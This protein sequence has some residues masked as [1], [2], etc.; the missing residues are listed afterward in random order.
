MPMAYDAVNALS[1][2]ETRQGSLN[3]DE[4]GE[5]KKGPTLCNQRQAPQGCRSHEPGRLALGRA[6]CCPCRTRPELSS[7]QDQNDRTTVMTAM[8]TGIQ[9]TIACLIDRRCSHRAQ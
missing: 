2:T 1:L 6:H 3:L 4:L 9:S 8:I 5:A 7:G